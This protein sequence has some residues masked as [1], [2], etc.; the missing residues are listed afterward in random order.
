MKPLTMLP[1]FVEDEDR[2]G[3][4]GHFYDA[5]QDND[6]AATVVAP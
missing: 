1:L 6:A 4:K 5:S 2:M 3:H